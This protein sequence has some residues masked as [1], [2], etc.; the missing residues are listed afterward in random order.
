M[1]ELTTEARKNEIISRERE[2]NEIKAKAD[3]ER[4]KV[5][6]M[7]AT[8]KEMRMYN[9]QLIQVGAPP[10]YL[11]CSVLH[12]RWHRWHTWQP[13]CLP[14]TPP[15]IATRGSRCAS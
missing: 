14:S 12:T 11:P 7:T 6:E 10:S 1:M 3:L 5:M 15:R 9:R 4:H 8:E 13:L 2:H